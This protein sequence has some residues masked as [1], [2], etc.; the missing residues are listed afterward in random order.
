MEDYFTNRNS[1]HRMLVTK[2]DDSGDIQLI[3]AEGLVGEKTTKIMRVYPHGFTSHAP[4]DAHFLAVNLGSRRDHLVA[5]GGEH[6][7]YRPKNI[8][9]GNTALYNADGSI[10]K[11]I[12]KDVTLNADGTLTIKVKKVVVECEKAVIKTSDRLD[13]GDEGGSKVMTEAGPSSKVYAIT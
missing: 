2:I 6:K 13:L 11:L 3:D 1:A 5:L 9:L 4:K 12:G 10:W 7:D 8:G